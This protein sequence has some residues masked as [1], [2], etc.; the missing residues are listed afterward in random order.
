VSNATVIGVT[1]AAGGTL[2]IVVSIVVFLVRKNR[3]QEVSRDS[4]IDD[5]D[6]FTPRS[7]SKTGTRSG[8]ETAICFTRGSDSEEESS[9][10]DIHTSIELS[11]E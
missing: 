5:K 1:A 2:A 8:R 4:T 7:R 10:S 6:L 9:Y 3:Q 11:G